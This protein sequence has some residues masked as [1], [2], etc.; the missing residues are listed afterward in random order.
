M[1]P[2]LDALD[3]F[4]ETGIRRRLSW[5]LVF[6]VGIAST[7]LMLALLADLAGWRLNIISG[8]LYFVVGSTFLLV[9]IL[10]ALL[11]TNISALIVAT[12][13][14]ATAVMAAAA[15]VQGTGGVD[16]PFTFLYILAILDAAIIGQRRA[17]LAVSISAT[18]FYG[19]Q[20]VAELY[21]FVL[22][23]FSRPQHTSIF[24]VV[25]VAHTLAFNL[26]GWL[27]GLLASQF[28]S[29]LEVAS[30]VKRS[31]DVVA[32]QH[33]VI[34][35]SLPV[36]VITVDEGGM[37]TSLNAMAKEMLAP[38]VPAEIG[39]PLPQELRSFSGGDLSVGRDEVLMQKDEVESAFLVS[40]SLFNLPPEADGASELHEVVVFED[41]T[42]W[43]ELQQELVR[44]ERLASVGGMAAA[45]AHEIR[46]PLSAISGAVQLLGESSAKSPDKDDSTRKLEKIVRREVERLDKLLGAFLLYARP[47]EPQLSEV[48]LRDLIDEIRVMLKQDLIYLDREIT[49]SAS[50]ETVMMGDQEELKQVF[51]NLL[52]NAAEASPIKTPI[53][54][55]LHG[56]ITERNQNDIEI[57]IRDYG[58]GVPKEIVA[59]LFE[60]FQSTKKSGSGLGLAIV[61]RIIH[62]HGGRVS[63]ES[64]ES[65]GTIARV[66]LPARRPDWELV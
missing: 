65:S 21:G 56:G 14:L 29:A 53:E 23:K 33:G 37:M 50:G 19:L 24:V 35:E 9:A 6:R 34:L 63:L 25:F 54:I 44:R 61:H 62:S 59:K 28:E 51:W 15:I 57:T 31:L 16:S 41:R 42:E 17:A 49:F 1:S 22:P 64:A 12:V 8:L 36:G 2:K 26:V 45:M 32:R 55:E 20:L 52:R 46:N 5:L 11:R 27:A 47:R 10:G 7:L 60:P 4:G 38:F 43:N 48:D 66:L 3:D 40:H 18:L 39:L 30:R 13:H 58:E